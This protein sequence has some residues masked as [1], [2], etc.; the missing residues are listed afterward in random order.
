[1]SNRSYSVKSFGFSIEKFRDGHASATVWAHL[2]GGETAAV[3][4]QSWPAGAPT[5]HQLLLLQAAVVEEVEKLILLEVGVQ[6]V[7]LAGQE[8]DL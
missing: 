1:M 2:L 6:G 3:F 4:S 8:L 7:L 5:P